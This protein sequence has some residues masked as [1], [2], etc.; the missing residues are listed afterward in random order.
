[1][2]ACIIWTMTPC[3]CSRKG[4]KPR[5]YGLLNL[6]H[7]SPATLRHSRRCDNESADNDKYT[8]ENPGLSKPSCIEDLARNWCTD[9]QANGDNCDTTLATILIRI[10]MDREMD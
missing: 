7:Q 6:D 9:E 2:Y 5:A 8:S 3:S 10:V 1:M 4:K